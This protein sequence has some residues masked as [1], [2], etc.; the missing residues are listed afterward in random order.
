MGIFGNHDDKRRAVID[1]RAVFVYNT[2]Q[3]ELAFGVYS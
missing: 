1:Q 2:S 3:L